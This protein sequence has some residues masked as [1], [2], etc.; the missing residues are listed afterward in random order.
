MTS[1]VQQASSTD[2]S[3]TDTASTT[4][5]KRLPERALPTLF[6]NAGVSVKAIL[7]EAAPK[8]KPNVVITLSGDY[9][10]YVTPSGRFSF[11]TEAWSQTVS[12]EAFTENCSQLAEAAWVDTVTLRFSE[13]SAN[14]ATLYAM[15]RALSKLTEAGKTVHAH[16]DNLE[17]RQLYLASVATTISMPESADIF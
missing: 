2:T 15:R 10:S 17:L 4:S 11:L 14:L 5:T 8:P 1:E 7:A 12:L 16:L 6:H 9:P 13:L 3:L